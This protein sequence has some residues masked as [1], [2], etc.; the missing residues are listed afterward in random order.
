[1]NGGLDFQ[2]SCK[3]SDKVVRDL[4]TFG[5]PTDWAFF[6]LP[7]AQGD[8]GLSC[9]QGAQC[10]GQQGCKNHKFSWAWDFAAI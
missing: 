10:L 6:R 3:L 2:F 8:T 5:C 4:V 1:M 9:S 7:F